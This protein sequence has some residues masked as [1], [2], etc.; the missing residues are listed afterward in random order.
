MMD[1][2]EFQN[3]LVQLDHQTS[4]INCSLEAYTNPLGNFACDLARADMHEAAV[5]IE[6]LGRMLGALASP[7]LVDVEGQMMLGEVSK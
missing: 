2:H 3:L 6:T 7:E 4:R 5:R 1:T